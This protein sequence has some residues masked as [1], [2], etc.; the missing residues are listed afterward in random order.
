MKKLLILMLPLMLIVAA[1]TADTEAVDEVD[2]MT[3]EQIGTM[4]TGLEADAET[5]I[6][7]LEAAE[8]ADQ[9]ADAV[10]TLRDET[11]I[12]ALAA[13]AGEVSDEDID[14]LVSSLDDLNADLE[15]V[16]DSLDPGLSGRI[17]SFESEMREAVDQLE[18]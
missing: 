16:R 6:A 17:D 18:G 11:G 9:V 15:A 4:L 8:G 10:R 1:C 7:D 14:R 12:V 2:D 3:V 5:L 13:T